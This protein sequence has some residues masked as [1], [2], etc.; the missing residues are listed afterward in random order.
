MFPA[1]KQGLL[2]CVREGRFDQVFLCVWLAL[3]SL[4]TGATG[5]IRSHYGQGRPLGLSEEEVGLVSRAGDL[6]SQSLR[7]P[8]GTHL[9]SGSVFFSLILVLTILYWGGEMGS[10]GSQSSWIPFS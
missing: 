2:G 5:G 9:V 6:G 4:V 8:F 7:F 1:D 10:D 3:Q